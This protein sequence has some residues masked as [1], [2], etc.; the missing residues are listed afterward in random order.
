MSDTVSGP[1]R[2][3]LVGC[4]AIAHHHA[5]A[6]LSVPGLCCVAVCDAQA[7]RAE[8]F[9]RAY[10]PDA[11]ASTNLEDVTPRADAAIVATP[12][13]LHSPVTLKLLRAGLHVLCE[14]PLAIKL[15]DARDLLATASAA[16]RVLQSRFM[17]FYFGSTGL[18]S[19]VLRRNIVGP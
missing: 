9:S 16:G 18:V 15:C 10:F 19:E 3:A 11:S 7:A 6:V 5:K 13:G 17:R 4:G 1:I 2:I 12:N 8:A 14:N